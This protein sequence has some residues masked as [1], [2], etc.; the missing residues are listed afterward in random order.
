M[1]LLQQL[2]PAFRRIV[3]EFGFRTTGGAIGVLSTGTL[4]ATALHSLLKRAPPGTWELVTHPGYNDGD[5]AHARTRLKESR[6]TEFEALK[7]IGE[8]GGM[9]LISF[10]QVG[11][12]AASMPMK[13]E[14]K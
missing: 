2:E 14:A 13:I 3:A 8:L 5:L 9:D 4:D 6:E 7:S 1:S 11:A 10:A 12:D